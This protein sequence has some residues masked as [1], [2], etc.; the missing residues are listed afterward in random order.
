MGGEGLTRMDSS[1][2]I[3]QYELLYLVGRAGLKPRLAGA[4]ET[5]VTP[6]LANRA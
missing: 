2:M 3:R 6:T 4:A 5:T 1:S